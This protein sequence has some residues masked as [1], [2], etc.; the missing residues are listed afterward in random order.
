MKRIDIV[1]NWLSVAGCLLLGSFAVSAWYGGNRTA[2]L[3]LAFGGIV[4]LELLGTLQ[5]QHIILGSN[6]PKISEAVALEQRPWVSLEVGLADG[7]SYD[8]KGW[9]AGTRWRTTIRYRLTNTGKTP[10]VKVSVFGGILP[11]MISYRPAQPP[12]ATPVAGTDVPAEMKPICDFA[13]IIESGEVLA[14]RESRD[15][16][17]TLNGNPDRFKAAK[18]SPGFSG[19]VLVI[20]CVSYASTFNAEKHMSAKAFQ[21][22]RRDGKGIDLKGEMIPQQQLGLVL[23]PTSESITN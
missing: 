2:A 4:C 3:W 5:I 8:D 19:N 12:Q 10:A 22:F 7:L 14:S 9:D 6:E 21:L 1:F 17:F 20:V 16:L 11:L 18:D 15:G 23:N 13:A